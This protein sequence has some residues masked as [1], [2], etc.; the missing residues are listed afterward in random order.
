[1]YVNAK[2]YL[3]AIRHYSRELDIRKKELRELDDLIGASAIQYDPV[4]IATSPKKDGLERQAINHAMKRDKIREDIENHITILHE[5]ID[6]AVSLIARIESEDQQ[7]VLMLRY[8]ERRSWADILTIRGCDSL[9]SL[10]KLH[11]R[12]LQSLQ[13]ILNE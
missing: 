11:K 4:R 1:M 13:R 12:A 5:K 2:Q 3:D 10:Y 9:E 6:R 7:D 8:I